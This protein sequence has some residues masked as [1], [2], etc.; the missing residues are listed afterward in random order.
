VPYWV[1][2]AEGKERPDHT[3]YVWLAG[4]LFNVYEVLVVV[5]LGIPMKSA[6]VIA[7]PTTLGR[8]PSSAR[9]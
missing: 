9:R 6:P 8:H 5:I 3:R 7:Y 2:D 1:T 4:T